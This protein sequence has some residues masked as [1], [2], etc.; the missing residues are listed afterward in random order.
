VYIF[1]LNRS[2]GGG[3]Q[4]F[5]GTNTR[6][7]FAHMLKI[8]LHSLTEAELR[9][10]APAASDIATHSSRKGAGSYCLGQVCGPSPTSVYLRMGQSLGKLKDRY[11]F[12]CDGGDQLTGRMV[13]CLPF[14]SDEFAVS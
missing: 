4:L 10:I 6:D 9:P 8:V 2:A 5:S 12:T 1:C 3:Q 14:D 11:I 13:A 7:R